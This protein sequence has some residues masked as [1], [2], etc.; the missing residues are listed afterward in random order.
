MV[1][2][3]KKG[4]YFLDMEEMKWKEGRESS[5]EKGHILNEESLGFILLP[6]H[7]RVFLFLFYWICIL[8]VMD[9]CEN[10][11]SFLYVGRVSKGY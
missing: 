8:L 11:F 7:T 4:G 9:I 3:P 6:V 10:P 2:L 5:S 1:T